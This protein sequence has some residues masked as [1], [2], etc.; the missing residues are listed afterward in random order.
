MAKSPKKTNR[1]KNNKWQTLEDKLEVIAMKE[2]GKSFA[3]IARDK[4][5][6][7]STVRYIFKKKDEIKS[8]GEVR[9]FTVHPFHA[10]GL[11]I[12]KALK[13]FLEAMASLFGDWIYFGQDENLPLFPPITHKC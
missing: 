9:P 3:Q 4:N 7:E 12:Q 5:L 6:P 2:S 13:E 11:R 10:P 1:P 8:Q